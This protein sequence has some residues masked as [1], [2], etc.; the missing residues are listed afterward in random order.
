MIDVVRDIAEYIDMGGGKHLSASQFLQHFLFSPEQQHNYVYKLS[1]GE[2]R[3]LYLCTVLMKNPNFLVLDEP[4]N[5]LD[6]QTLQILEEYLADFPGCIIVISHDRYF[7]DK[8]VDHLLVFKGNGV[9]K[10]FP[11]NYTQYREWLSLQSNNDTSQ[12]N[13]NAAKKEKTSYRHDERR[14]MTFK[15]KREYEQLE[16][17]IDALEKEQKLIEEQLCSGTLTVAEITE[18]SQRLPSLKEELDEKSMR[19]LELSE[20]L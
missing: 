15:E 6:I 11:G 5:D 14:K 2:K 18:K 19:W 1:G 20:L 12:K 16:K 10:D 17:D 9:I 4:T 13:D 8:V 3:K 7:T